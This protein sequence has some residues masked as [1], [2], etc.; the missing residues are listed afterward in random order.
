MSVFLHYS[1]AKEGKVILS[2]VSWVQLAQVLRKLEGRLP[3][4]LFSANEV[5]PFGHPGHMY[6][7]GADKL[8]RR[9]LIPYAEVHSA[10]VFSYH[11]AKEH[12]EPFA[13]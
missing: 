11:P 2:G 3:I 9:D 4:C 5:E 8:G 12:V 13:A 6:I 1:Q 10:F 7:E